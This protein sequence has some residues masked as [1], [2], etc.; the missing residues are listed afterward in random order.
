MREIGQRLSVIAIAT[1]V[2]VWCQGCGGS[3]SSTPP[4]EAESAPTSSPDELPLDPTLQ[5]DFVA[6]AIEGGTDDTT[7]DFPE[8]SCQVGSAEFFYCTASA[9]ISPVNGEL[10][11]SDPPHS[12]LASADPRTGEVTVLYEGNGGDPSFK[13]CDANTDLCRDLL[14]SGQRL[15]E[16]SEVKAECPPGEVWTGAGAGCVHEDV[17]GTA[18]A[19]P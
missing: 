5:T 6:G 14:T 4:E 13:T 17:A 7:S 1:L 12:F 3:D 18:E 10:I 19:L 11:E 8:V 15:S 16:R 2:A 9:A